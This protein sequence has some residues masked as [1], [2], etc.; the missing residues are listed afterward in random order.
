MEHVWGHCCLALHDDE[1]RSA[2]SATTSGMVKTIQCIHFLNL[3]KT[4]MCADMS[5]DYVVKVLMRCAGEETVE[6]DPSVMKHGKQTVHDDPVH[7]NKL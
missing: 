6:N 3:D 1:E 5:L 7:E 4:C 2:I